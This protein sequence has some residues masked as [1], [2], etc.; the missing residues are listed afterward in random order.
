MAVPAR[1][2]REIRYSQ[3][4][5]KGN[6]SG[7]DDWGLSFYHLRDLVHKLLWPVRILSPS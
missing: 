6:H 2:E 3:V 4:L 7:P 1:M 5:L